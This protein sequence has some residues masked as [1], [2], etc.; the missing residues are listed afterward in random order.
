MARPVPTKWAQREDKVYLTF[1]NTS[2][3]DWKVEFEANKVIFKGTSGKVEYENTLELFDEILKGEEV[4]ENGEKNTAV[5]RGLGIECVAYKKNH[6]WWTRLLSQ[7]IK[8]HWLKVDFKRWKDEDD[9]EVEEDWG[10]TGDDE[11]GMG[12]MGG[13]PDLAQMMQQMGGGAAMGTDAMGGLSDDS[14][15]SD[16]EDIPGLE[17]DVDQPPSIQEL[18]DEKVAS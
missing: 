5:K 8:H 17:N 11:G 18:P 1:E 7:K 2:C 16:D 3:A 13:Q 10:A 14:D 6:S 4:G 9:S 12:G 15:D